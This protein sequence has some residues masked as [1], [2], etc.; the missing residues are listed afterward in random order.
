MILGILFTLTACASNVAQSS[1]ISS[2][3]T[4][5]STSIADSSSTS[6]TTSSSTSST[7]TSALISFNLNGGTT[8]S[9]TTSKEVSSIDASNFFFN[10]TKTNYKFRGWSYNNEKIFDENQNKLKD[11]ELSENMTFLAVF[12]QKV[13]LT[14][15]LNIA[16]AGS[17]SENNEYD[18][19][20]NVD[21]FAHPNQGYYFIGWYYGDISLSNQENYNYKMW[22]DDISLIAMFD[23][24]DYTLNIKSSNTDLGQVQVRSTSSDS[25]KDS[26][27]V[28]KPYTKSV[29]IAAYSKTETRFL[30]WYDK[31]NKLISPNAVYTFTM[32]NCNYTLEAKW[33]KFFI[34]YDLDGG[35]VT[36]NAAYYTAGST[37]ITVTNPTKTG[38]TFI[39]WTGSNETTPNKNV[40]ILTGSLEDKSYKANYTANKYTITYDV[41]EGNALPSTTQIV[42][43][44]SEYTLVT[45]IR[46]G[47][48]FDGW[49]SSINK[50]ESGTWTKTNDLTLVAKWTI[51]T[52]TVEYDLNNGELTTENPTSY[53]ILSSDFT[54]NNPTKTGY[55]FL[56][57]TGSNSTT[58]E[59]SVEVLV[60]SLENKSYTANFSANEYTITYDVSGGNPLTSNTQIVTYGSMFMLTNATK[61]N[62]TFDGWYLDDVRIMGG[63]WSRT[64]DVTLIARWDNFKISVESGVT[65]VYYGKY[66]QTVVSDTTLISSLASITTTNSLGYIEYNG[67]EYLKARATPFSLNSTIIYFYSN[68]NF[69]NSNYDYYFKVEPIKWRVLSK[70]TGEYQIMSEYIL[71]YQP[72]YNSSLSREID[73]NTIYP[74]NYEYSDIR[75]WLNDDFYNEAFSTITQRIKTVSVDNSASTTEYSS[76]KYACNNTLDKLYLLSCQ[77]ALNTSY[78]FSSST[79][80]SSTRYAYATDYARAMGV[81][82]SSEYNNSNWLLRSPSS[83]YSTQTS[84]V[85]TNGGIPNANASKSAGVRPACIITIS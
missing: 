1:I 61:S 54:L 24:V 49:Y 78:G 59:K 16:G 33:N 22:S 74:N 45:P 77:D 65:Y 11:I 18:F 72:Y 21:I 48:T 53:T 14:I 60:S 50:I 25:Y 73:G 71:D 69:I 36:S 68:T 28:V 64:E 17:V 31:D 57:W 12:D 41:N 43:Y 34:S 42:T 30:G 27:S 76:N 15:T 19:N 32:P 82:V 67:E 5:S 51:N 81:Y 75:T 80:S 7:I 62:Y 83:N 4:T 63:V 47:Y 10:V 6:I 85:N 8:I 3:T 39:G 55:T 79:S 44:D 37:N 84:C 35:K 70:S 56:G 46:T 13:K 52:Y 23:Y 20:S 58:P 26:E 38:Y 40:V 2:S 29:T 9:D 66:P